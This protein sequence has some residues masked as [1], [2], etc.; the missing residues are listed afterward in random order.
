MPLNVESTLTPL[1]LAHLIQG[2]GYWV[3]NTI[4]LCTYKFTYEEVNLLI[5]V[6]ENKFGLIASLKKGATK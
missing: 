1:G 6:L 2:D 5:K 4:Y 3:D